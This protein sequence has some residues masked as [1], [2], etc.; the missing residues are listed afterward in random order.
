[1]QAIH[2]QTGK[3][4]RILQTATQVTKTNRTLLWHVNTLSDDSRWQRWSV[5]ITEPKSLHTQSKPEIAFIYTIKTDEEKQHWLKWLKTVTNETLIIATPEVMVQL[6][7]NA[8]YSESLLATSEFEFRYPFLP[9]L[10]DDAPIEDW[11]LNIAT[12]MR[13]HRI[14]TTKSLPTTNKKIQI[15]KIDPN[16]KAT[17]VVPP[18]YLIQQYFK[19]PE[20]KRQQEINYVLEQNCKCDL[21]D[22][23]ILL[24]EENF[25]LPINNQKIEQVVIKKRL[26]YLDV[27]SYIKDHVPK[28]TYV[29]FSNTDI[30]LDS[31]LCAIY[32]LQMEKKFISLLRY[33]ITKDKAPTLFGPRPDSQDTWIL[34]SSSVDFT[35][36]EEQFGFPFGISGCDNAINVA[37]LREKFTVVNPALTIKT[38]H[39]HASNV[40]TYVKSAVIDKPVFLYLTPTAIQEY[41]PLTDLSQYELSTWSRKPP[42]SFTRQIKYID[43]NSAE[44]LCSMLEKQS[45]YVFSIDSAN[46]FNQGFANHD[47]ILYKFTD[48]F[49][50]PAGIVC[51]E[52]TLFV[53]KHPAWSTEWSQAALTVLTNTVE[54]PELCAI[55][56]PESLAKSTARWALH[57]LSKALA[58][59]KHLQQKPEFLVPNHPDTQRFLQYLNWPEHVNMTPYLG[60]SQFYSKTVYALTPC[61]TKEV[62]YESIEALRSLLPKTEEQE[63]TTVVIVVERDSNAIFTSA[64]AAELIKNIFTRG[65]WSTY[66]LDADEKTETRLFLLQKADIL[67][68]PSNS[69]WEALSWS[70][71]LKPGKSVIELMEL[72]NPVGENIHLS[73]A[74]LLNHILVAVKN[75]PLHYQR[76][77]AI[78]DIQKCCEQHIF[79]GTYKAQVPKSAIPTIILPSDNHKGDA[80]REMVDIW[81]ERQYCAVQIRDDTPYVWW[82]KIGETLLFDGTT[83]YFTN[84][85]SY[86]LA[87]YGNMYPQQ[88]TARDRKWSFWGRHPKQ[89]EEAAKSHIKTY[90]ERKTKSI[91]LGRIENGVQKSNRT[92]Q[93]WSK[94]IEQFSMPVDSTEGPH[95][96]TQEE[97]LKALSN[98]RFGLC[99]P[100]YGPKCNREIEYLALGT[101]PIITPGVDFIN[102][103]VPPIKDLHY[104]AAETPEQVQIIV[105]TT[106][107]ERWQAMSIAGRTWWHRYAS[108]EGLFRLTWGIIEETQRSN[109]PVLR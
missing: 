84:N 8:E 13:F 78:E 101:V 82:Q 77:H 48:A 23:I 87:L 44:T 39:V 69:E 85:P 30:Y 19:S 47:N 35:P 43:K 76:Q 98:A 2:P 22:K 60:D 91:F 54:V 51:N 45:E 93:D 67:I 15:L 28:E 34:W 37:M 62:T 65:N 61:S 20:K 63:Q 64:W 11:I 102:Y 75:E 105:E 70:W 92:K 7:L 52:N 16:A 94:V 89:L 57:Y 36:T 86:K 12:L 40:R 26:T 68:A 106:P 4:I 103:Q 49:T 53:G 17:D 83:P 55:H 81:R 24:N 3:P 88:P 10:K 100:G 29:V 72:R 107:P 1:M 25:S 97:Y 5:I 109:P 59:R 56:F 66:I 21:I 74:A 80:F 50:M 6:R 99:L 104:F 31:T 27:L 95:R 90:K 9:I 96:F 58:I 41:S 33:D 46:T 71:L 79:A 18:V 108:A 73:G 42:Q 14:V 38:Y 32:S